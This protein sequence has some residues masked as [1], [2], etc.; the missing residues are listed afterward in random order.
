MGPQRLVIFVKAPRGGEVKTRLAQSIGPEAACA[1][2]RHLVETLLANFDAPHEPDART[3]LTRPAPSGSTLSPP[4]RRGEGWGEGCALVR[5]EDRNRGSWQ[6]VGSLSSG[7]V[8]GQ[9]ASR[10]PQTPIELRFTPDDALAEIQPWLRE[11][12]RAR[13]Q[14]GGDLGERLKRA[15]AEHFADGC[16]H[17]ILIGSDCP[18]VTVDDIERARASLKH[19]DVVLGP[20]TDGGYWLIGLN[21]PHLELFDEIP[22]ST[23]K[24]LARTLARA[25]RLQQRVALLRE[26]R[27][28]DTVEDWQRLHRRP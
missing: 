21:A 6:A 18:D 9:S 26:L 24:V 15:C 28:V 25:E 19:S 23:D 12:W 5:S 4:P 8:S 14:G 13:P 2:Y 11:G 16:E 10:K 22:W 7:A 1:A 17:L 3:P 27:D 20:A